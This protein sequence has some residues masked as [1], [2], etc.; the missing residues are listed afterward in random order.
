MLVHPCASTTLVFPNGTALSANTSVNTMHSESAPEKSAYEQST[1]LH[2]TPNR[3]A[4]IARFRMHSEFYEHRLE[5]IRHWDRIPPLERDEVSSVPVSADDGPAISARTSGTTGT[6]VTVHYSRREELIRR[7]LNFR[8]FHYCRELPDIVVHAI[9]KDVDPDEA[10]SQT[11]VVSVAGRVYHRQ[12]FSARAPVEAQWRF[13]R[14]IR[15]HLLTSFPSALVRFVQECGSRSRRLGIRVVSPG[16]EFL[17]DEWRRELAAFE[18]PVRD[19]YGATETGALAW[20]CPDCGSYHANT[21]A[22]LMEPQANGLLVTPLFQRVQP[23]LR[24]R[25][26][27]RLAWEDGVATACGVPLPRVRILAGRKD[28]WLYDAADKKVSP[29]A[30]EFEQFEGLRRWSMRQNADGSID[31]G[32]SWATP[33]NATRD[34]ALARE[35]QCWIPG[36]T[37][38]VVD[39]SVLES[40]GKFRRVRSHYV[41]AS[42]R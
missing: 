33:S 1:K 3:V 22:Q 24:Y 34:D 10:R 19:R 23:L 20:Q 42:S 16:G 2:L 25:L 21:D 5:G 4:L 32:L 40:F 8:L 13:L 39:I 15:P 31:V 37:V 11:E 12:V 7:R 27:D 17:S 35:V 28:H 26:E 30:L 29:V 6:R 14:S 38:R 41:P 36:R 18:A 9:I